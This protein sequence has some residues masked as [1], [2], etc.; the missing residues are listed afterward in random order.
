M[1]RS[2]KASANTSASTQPPSRQDGPPDILALTDSVRRRFHRLEGRLQALSPETS[3]VATG[4]AQERLETLRTVLDDL[5]SGDD[6]ADRIKAA[7]GAA[8]DLQVTV[9]AMTRAMKQTEDVVAIREDLAELQKLVAQMPDVAEY[10]EIGVAHR[11]RTEFAI[12]DIAEPTDYTRFRTKVERPATLGP[13]IL[14]GGRRPVLREAEGNVLKPVETLGKVRVRLH[15]EDQPVQHAPFQIVGTAEDGTTRVLG[16]GATNAQ[17][18]AALNLDG[19]RTDTFASVAVVVGSTDARRD[20]TGGTTDSDDDADNDDSSPPSTVVPS[21]YVLRAEI[22]DAHVA[23]H[24]DRGIAHVL[25]LRPEIARRVRDLVAVGT[26]IEDPDAKDAEIDPDA[27]SFET[28]LQDGNCCIK[29]RPELAARQYH[30]RQV[31]RIDSPPVSVGDRA[32]KRREVRGPVPYGQSERDAHALLSSAIVRGR[33]NLYR[34]AWYPNGQGLGRILYSLT[35]AP[36]EQVNLAMIDWQRSERASRQEASSER[37]ALSAELSRDRT[38]DELVETVLDEEQSGSSGGGG[39]GLSLDLGFFS[40][41]G[42]GGG[43]TS[44]S[45]GRRELVA[46][47]VQEVSDRTVQR[48]SAYRSQRSTVV[49]TSRQR[50]SERIQTRTVRNHNKNHA[51]TV[52]YHQV[53]SHYRARTELI[54]EQD[55]LLVPYDIPDAVFD[56]IPSFNKFVIAPSR[57]ITRFLDRHRAVLQRMVPQRY[58]SAFASLSRLL[59]CGDVYAIEEPYAT[60]SRWRIELDQGFREG[61][62]IEIETTDGQT[63]PLTPRERIAGTSAAY[64]RSDPVRIDA[65]ERVRVSY[66][67]QQDAAARAKEIGS[68]PFLGDLSGALAESLVGTLELVLKRIEVSIRTDRSRFVQEPQS[69]LRV[70]NNPNTTLSADNPTAAFDIDAPE[71]SFEGYRGREHRDYC[72]LKELIAHIQSRPMRYLRAIWMREDADRRAL[73]FDSLLFDGEPLLDQIQNRAVGVMGNLVAFPLLEGHRLVEHDPVEHV[74]SERLVSLPTRGLFAETY[75]SCCNATEVRDVT[76]VI[77]PGTGCEVS[78][79]EI[80]GV[81]PGSRRDRPDTTPTPFPA[82]MIN[83]QT[84]EAT[85][86]PTGLANALS[87]LGTPNIFRDMSLGSEVMSLANNAAMTAFQN[88]REWHQSV[89]DLAGQILPSLIGAAMGVPIPPGGAGGSGSSGSPLPSLKG[90]GDSAPSGPSSISAPPNQALMA[91]NADA[92]RSTPPQQLFDHAQAIQRAMDSGALTSAQGAAATHALYT[93]GLSDQGIV[94]AA[95]PSSGSSLAEPRSRP[96]CI[97]SP[98]VFGTNNIVEI[99]DLTAH[100]YSY[101]GGVRS[102]EKNGLLYTCNGGFVDLGHLRDVADWTGYL[103][104]RTKEMLGQGG[105]TFTMTPDGATSM[106]VKIS[107]DSQGRPGAGSAAS[108]PDE[109]AI[110][111]GQRIAYDRA[112]WHEIWTWFQL[113]PGARNSS[114]SPEDNFSN[115]LGALVGGDALRSSKSFDTAVVDALA[116]R[117]APLDPVSKADTEKAY[118]AIKA[119]W[120]DGTKQ[121]TD[122]DY[123]QRRHLDALGTVTPWLVSG[124]PGC[125]SPTATSL[126]APDGFTWPPEASATPLSEYYSLEIEVDTSVVPTSVLP[127]GKT[128]VTPADFPHIVGEVRN[129]VKAKYG[130]SADQP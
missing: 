118:D 123:L 62:E 122:P 9:E 47:T 36:C 86:A 74:V 111:V 21:A 108:V 84:P 51:L 15:S 44:S 125:S 99:G 94:L 92:V 113:S 14:P 35:L 50:E 79:P 128:T 32:I 5:E 77:D 59:Y 61:V 105:G 45:E 126:T 82:P 10:L 87:V 116:A 129:L 39:G 91:A 101:T 34:Q 71:V 81:T 29:P 49:T 24:R 23:T 17:G 64:F 1:D 112:V 37:E 95:Y 124:V 58:R 96:C 54:E 104:A 69:F 73:R 78:A 80:T 119:T 67:A 11:P 4:A 52:H 31:V 120:V 16:V 72:R 76:R 127:P 19:L 98:T 97:L 55:V 26:Y 63:V 8:I 75:L 117:L 25:E 7:R 68:I 65:I 6:A 43:A 40:I 114:F 100:S 33:V 102:G 2:K 46:S 27:F 110:T 106:V 48:A 130:A 83:I 3:L 13:T 88:T 30:F 28:G 121:L 12:P 41:G 22:L 115:L 109:L 85:P 90:S 66:N 42:G 70:V 103:A 107:D 18:Y 60:C 38:V 56:D 89:H 93:G 53:L 57:P 20:P